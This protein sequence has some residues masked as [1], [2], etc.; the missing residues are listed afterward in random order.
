MPTQI[1][2]DDLWVIQQIDGFTFQGYITGFEDI[3]VVS[4][5]ESH[6]GIL[7]DEKDTGAL[8]IDILD[9][10]E[11]LFDQ[12]GGKAHRGFIEQKEWGIL[13]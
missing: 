12:N 2:F 3:T 11:N 7:F 5:G 1:G 8:R 4:H 13:Y 9:D 10:V 6:L